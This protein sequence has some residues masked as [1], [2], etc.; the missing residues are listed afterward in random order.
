[1]HGYNSECSHL[2]SLKCR[3]LRNLI[4]MF[5]GLFYVVDQLGYLS[6]LTACITTMH[7]QICLASCKLLSSLDTWHAYAMASFLCLE[8][9]DSVPP[10]S[11][12]A[13]FTGRLNVSSWFSF[14]SINFVRKEI[15]DF[16]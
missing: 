10:F 8:Q 11:L 9:W 14:L 16:S 7:G 1:M 12:F 4:L 6:M 13:T 15:I 5:T 3:F 2:L